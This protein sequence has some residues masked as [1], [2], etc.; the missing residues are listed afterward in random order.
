MRILIC[1]IGDLFLDLLKDSLTSSKHE[2]CGTAEKSKGALLL[3]AKLR[4]DAALVNPDLR[5]R[6]HRS[7]SRGRPRCS[8]CAVGP[9]REEHVCR[10]TCHGSQGGAAHAVQLD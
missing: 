8:W 3:V 7:W 5:N 9:D 1:E 2:V 4:P 6:G 10:A